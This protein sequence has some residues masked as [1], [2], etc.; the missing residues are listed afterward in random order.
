MSIPYT[1]THSVSLRANPGAS[2]PIYGKSLAELNH[3]VQRVINKNCKD[4][5][6]QQWQY[7]EFFDLDDLMRWMRSGKLTDP[8]TNAPLDWNQYDDVVWEDPPPDLQPEGSSYAIETRERLARVRGSLPVPPQRPLTKQ[9]WVDWL[10]SNLLGGRAVGGPQPDREDLLYLSKLILSRIS[11]MAAPSAQTSAWLGTWLNAQPNA[12]LSA[13]PSAWLS[14]P[15]S[16][17][18]NPPPSAPPSVWHSAQPSVWPSIG[19]SAG[20]QG[21]DQRMED[22]WGN[23]GATSSARKLT[24][25]EWVAWVKDNLFVVG[26]GGREGPQP[27]RED[28]LDFCR[29]IQDWSVEHGCGLLLPKADE[30][31]MDVQSQAQGAPVLTRGISADQML[32]AVD[33]PIASR[34]SA[35]PLAKNAPIASRTSAL[36]GNAP[37]ASNT[38]AL[39]GNA[40]IASRTSALPKNTQAGGAVRKGAGRYETLPRD[41]STVHLRLLRHN[42]TRVKVPPLSALGPG[43]N[44]G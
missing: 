44:R 38:S 24:V 41:L 6:P 42:D 23:D 33:S 17:W 22:A 39:T 8:I 43:A 34:T 14:A 1:G 40:P 28:L 5:N 36:P 7:G 29:L 35:L 19:L 13:P 2:D 32:M 9:Q 10:R 25:E 16:T 11:S 27:T 12:W 21:S 20:R 30:E 37:I 15:P 3:P 4:E 26:G 31:M 18:P